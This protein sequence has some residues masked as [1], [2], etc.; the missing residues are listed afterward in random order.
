MAAVLEL[1]P[2]GA[3]EEVIFG[4]EAEFFEDP[5]ERREEARVALKGGRRERET[6]E[7]EKKRFQTSEGKR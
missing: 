1:W 6:K 3:A 5:E 2:S 4:A 7:G